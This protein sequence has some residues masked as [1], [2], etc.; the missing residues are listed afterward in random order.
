MSKL[1]ISNIG[2][3]LNSSVGELMTKISDKYL[4][5]IGELEGV[6]N[7]FKTS[8]E[9]SKK[10]KSGQNTCIY[11]FIKPPRFGEVC[12]IK[13]RASGCSYCS[14]H[15]AY[16]GKE[17]RDKKVLPKAKTK[18]ADDDDKTIP[19]KKKDI[20]IRLD[21]KLN[22][23]VHSL[24]GMVFS[25]DK[26]VVCGRLT[27]DKVVELSD[28]DIEICKKYGFQVEAATSRN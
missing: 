2:S 22:K 16:E 8:V 27:V 18:V 23:Y 28:E 1:F 24:T 21:S 15:K 13:V 20:V 11:K 5:D 6:W 7:E 3:S 9:E 4:M 17:Q 26:R 25:K 19:V 12:G 10:T 14:K